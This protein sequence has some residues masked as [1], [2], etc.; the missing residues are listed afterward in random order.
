MQGTKFSNLNSVEEAN[1]LSSTLNIQKFHPLQDF[2]IES[3]LKNANLSKDDAI[4]YATILI[5]SSLSSQQLAGALILRRLMY[6][7]EIPYQ[8]V[9]QSNV[10]PSLIQLI[11]YSD[12]QFIYEVSYIILN[13]AGGDKSCNDYLLSQNSLDLLNYLLEK[14]NSI[15]IFEHIMW[16]IGNIAITGSFYQNLLLQKL[17][18]TAISNFLNIHENEFLSENFRTIAWSLAL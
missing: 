4:K 5:S 14:Y 3:E 16:T 7:A 9:I 10:L 2:L 18:L 1:E 8:K 15:P 13:I 11:S 12:E 17:N 6:K